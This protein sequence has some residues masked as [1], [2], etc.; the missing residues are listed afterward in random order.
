MILGF[1]KM[2]SILWKF[3]GNCENYSKSS[4]T[5]PNETK[6]LPIIIFNE[7]LVLAANKNQP[8]ILLEQERKERRQ[9]GSTAISL[10]KPCLFPCYYCST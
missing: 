10:G 6:K 4:T 3:L 9:N 5:F 7:L 8:E 1:E 2:D